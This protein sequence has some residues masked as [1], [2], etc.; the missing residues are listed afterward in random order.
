MKNKFWMLIASIVIAFALWLYVITVVSPGSQETYYNV[1]VVLQG[2]AVLEDRGL[3]IT[4]GKNPTVTLELGGNRTDLIEL[5][6]ANITVIADLSKIYEA[7]EHN[8]FYDISYPGSI[9][10]NAIEEL[11][12]S[13]DTITLTVEQLVSKEIPVIINWSGN[14]PSG[15][16]AEKAEAVLDYEMIRVEGPASVISQITQAVMDVN[17]EGRTES[18]SESARYTLVNENGEGVDAQLVRTNVAQVNVTMMIQHTKEVPLR[19]EI[20]DG[21]GATAETTSIVIKKPDS[22]EVINSIMV[23]GSAS[24]LEQ[25]DEIVVATIDLANYMRDTEVTFQLNIPAAVDNLSNLTQ[26]VA[27]IKFPALQTTTFKVTAFQLQNIPEGMEAQMVTQELTIRVRGP[28]ELVDKMNADSFAVSVDLAG[29]GL[30]TFTKQATVTMKSEFSEVGII[31]TYSVSVT[32]VDPL[33]EVAADD[34]AG[35]NTEG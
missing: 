7:G 15:Y 25:L 34:P 31:G 26:V 8:L 9:A 4:D 5:N 24:A 23:A 33:L 32:V 13:P 6:S 22:D 12:R 3:I 35:T 17:I 30:G 18:F 20:I 2:E 10:D 29:E 1:P 28:K 19:I 14:V 27:E 21:G 11:S 16:R